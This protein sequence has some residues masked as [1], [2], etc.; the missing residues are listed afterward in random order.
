M[1]QVTFLL[2]TAPTNLFVDGPLRN[3]REAHLRIQPATLEIDVLFT[4]RTRILGSKAIHVMVVFPGRSPRLA[5]GPWGLH[6]VAL[7]RHL[8]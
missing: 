4:H 5:G 8:F 3:N 1:V 7:Q 6:G 2:P